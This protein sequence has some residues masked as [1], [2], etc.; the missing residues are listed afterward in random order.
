MSVSGPPPTLEDVA[1]AAGVSTATVSRCLNMPDKVSAKTRDT[2]MGAVERLGYTPNFGARVMASNKSF[3]IGA[4]IPTM[5]NAIFARGLQA[6]QEALLAHGYTLLVASSAYRPDIEAEQIKSLIGRGVDGLLLIGAE[7]SQEVY[8]Y[9]ERRG[10]PTVLAWTLSQQ[11]G[12][13]SVGFDNHLAMRSLAAQV[14]AKGHR[15]IA[16]ISGITRG[17]D[18][19]AERL[20]GVRDALQADGLNPADMPVIEAPYEIDAGARAFDTLIH[21][22]P[23]LTAVMCGNDVLA[24]GAMTRARALGM[25]LPEDVS[26]TGFD[27]IELARLMIPGLTTVHVPHRSMGRQAAHTLIH[28]IEGQKIGPSVALK[29]SVENRHSL[30]APPR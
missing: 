9:L 12:T 22:I 26:I 25:R 16:M 23:R 10:V 1:R 13:V 14:I 27:D 4:I 21:R 5:E 17:N 24:A 20:R 18:R 15:D 11:P 3:T 19:A 28:M 8:E 6:F 29:T 7:R 30:G 2:V